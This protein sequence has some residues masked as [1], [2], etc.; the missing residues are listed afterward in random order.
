M[1]ITIG[2]WII[3]LLITFLFISIMFF[4][5]RALLDLCVPDLLAIIGILF[6]WLI[7]F[8]IF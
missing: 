4:R 8:I 1:T 6:S 5:E 7:Y 2:W 3:P